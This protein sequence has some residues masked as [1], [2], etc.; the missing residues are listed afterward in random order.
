MNSPEAILVATD[1]SESAT[2]A[3]HQAS[4]IAARLGYRLHILHVIDTLELDP[5]DWPREGDIESKMEDLVLSLSGKV[6]VETD[7]K[8]SHAA[9]AILQEADNENIAALVVG[10]SGKS[11]F[12]QRIGST[13]SKVARRSRKPV[14][15]LTS[16]FSSESAVIGCLDFSETSRTVIDWTRKLINTGG[17]TGQYAHVAIP[18]KRLIEYNLGGGEDDSPIPTFGGS[19]IRYRDQV[20]RALRR[21]DGIDESDEIEICL[22][23]SPQ[24]GLEDLAAIR[25]PA[26]LVLGRTEHSALHDRIMGSTSEQI[27]DYSG[28]STLVVAG[29]GNTF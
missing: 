17:Y 1:F 15:I 14:F 10:Y 23:D 16:S 6:A 18:L 28:C 5:V 8:E 21:L 12:F 27:L 26:L 25:Y 19:E 29:K 4:D 22:N 7:I 20:E 11:G 13:A 9:K 3:V 2:A 24:K